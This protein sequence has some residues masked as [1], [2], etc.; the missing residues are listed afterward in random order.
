VPAVG[1][2]SLHE[3]PPALGLQEVA[4]VLRRTELIEKP[5]LQIRLRLCLCLPPSGAEPNCPGNE[6]QKRQCKEE[7]QDVVAAHTKPPL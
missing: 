4:D 1:G 2:H 3:K 6:A 5:V 7:R